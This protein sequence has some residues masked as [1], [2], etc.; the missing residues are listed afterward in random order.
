MRKTKNEIFEFEL[1]NALYFHLFLTQCIECDG[2]VPPEICLEKDFKQSRAEKRSPSPRE[3]FAASEVLQRTI[4]LYR[5][6]A[7]SVKTIKDIRGFIFTPVL[8][9]LCTSEPLCIVMLERPDGF[10]EFGLIDFKSYDEKILSTCPGVLLNIDHK[11]CFGFKFSNNYE[12]LF[13]RSSYGHHDHATDLF[14]RFSL[15]FYNDD[16]HFVRIINTICDF[17]LKEEN[18]DLFYKYADESFSENTELDEKER[19]LRNHVERVRLQSKSPGKGEMLAL[20]SVLNVDIFIGKEDRD[21]WELYMPVT[22]TYIKCYH[23]PILLILQKHESSSYKPHITNKKECACRQDKPV[24]LGHIGM[25]AEN[26]HHTVFRASCCPSTRHAFHKHLDHIPNSRTTWPDREDCFAPNEFIQIALERLSTEGRRIDQINGGK[27]T[28]TCAL[29]KEIYERRESFPSELLDVL[30]NENIQLDEKLQRVAD[31][32]SLPIYIFNMIVMHSE[33]RPAFHWTRFEPESLIQTRKQRPCRFYITLFFDYSNDAFDRIIPIG[34]CN[35]HLPP[36]VSLLQTISELETNMTLQIEP[37]MRQRVFDTYFSEVPNESLYCTEVRDFPPCSPYS[38]LRTVQQRMDMKDRTIDFVEFSDHSLLRCLS[39]EIF[40][41]EQHVDFLLKELTIEIQ[42]NTN[43]YLPFIE[44]ITKFIFEE[45]FGKMKGSEKEI[46]Q[47]ITFAI[48]RIEDDLPTGDVLLWVISTF[49][50]IEVFVLRFA[51]SQSSAESYWTE[52][53]PLRKKKD[54]YENSRK[55]KTFLTLLETQTKR[56]YRVVSKTSGCSCEL[57]A[58]T[59][60]NRVQDPLSISSNHDW[61]VTKQMRKIEAMIEIARDAIDQWL[62]CNLLLQQTCDLVI[63]EM[64]LRRRN[65]NVATISGSSVGI[66]GAVLT[67]VGIGIAP[68]TAGASLALSVTG[69]VLAATGG[70]VAA[71][72]KITETI[73]N[74]KTIEILK[75]YQDGYQERFET[76]QVNLRLL[77]DEISRLGDIASEM[78]TNQDIETFDFAALQSLPGILRMVKGLTMIPLA[79]LRIS[80]R[81]ISILG[82]VIGP[83]SALIDVGFLAFSIR[84]MVKRNKTDVTENLRR[85]SAS[86]FGSR[87]QMHSWAYGNQKVFF[88]D[89]KYFVKVQ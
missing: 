36:P 47:L 59:V 39:K 26:I 81:G 2:G 8:R 52:Y 74:T 51:E 6:C 65:V 85:I 19:L 23:S 16:E 75:R 14:K 27:G 56:F 22:S 12:L 35:C 79:V 46:Q 87:R 13:T 80:A 10:P 69:G 83:L 38:G 25:I 5:I 71:G 64:E 62:K 4:C 41:T 73:L 55:R 76:V 48:S 42:Q 32:S 31:W 61:R 58:P 57:I 67:A 89:S 70:T 63:A 3:I 60:P 40:G 18:V 50:Q 77:T 86:L 29:T 34:G 11:D 78:K 30:E 66:I 33:C 45:K 72:A 54:R 43:F 21:C 44:N 88:H 82:V 84:N 28:L 20:S 53:F 37:N 49:F 24:I 7:S 1:Q 68:F 15:E 17:E 9:N